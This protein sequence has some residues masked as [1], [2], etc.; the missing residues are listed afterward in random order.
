[1][2]FAAPDVTAADDDG[3]RYT[4]AAHF[5]NLFR[6]GF[7]RIDVNPG[8]ISGERLAGDL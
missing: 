5:R 3:D 7:R 6:H 1:M 4:S 2:R 8:V